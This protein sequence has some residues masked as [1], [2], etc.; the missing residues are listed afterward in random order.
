[1]SDPALYSVQRECDY[2]DAVGTLHFA[3]ELHT[4]RLM[5]HTARQSTD[6]LA[7]RASL[8]RDHIMS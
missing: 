6:N 3:H 8:F 1:M 4:E 2:D 5:V 7:R